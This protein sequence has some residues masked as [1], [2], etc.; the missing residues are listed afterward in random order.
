MNDGNSRIDRDEGRIYELEDNLG[1]G[2]KRGDIK[3]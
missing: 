3:C 2:I 1:G